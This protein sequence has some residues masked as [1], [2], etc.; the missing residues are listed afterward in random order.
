MTL[1]VKMVVHVMIVSIIKL[2]ARRTLYVNWHFLISHIFKTENEKFL[3]NHIRGHLN[4]TVCLHIMVP[5]VG[6]HHVSPSWVVPL[7]SIMAHVL[8]IITLQLV[9]LV[10]VLLDIAVSPVNGLPVLQIHV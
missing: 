4:A 6:Y 2:F 7:V 3:K 9:M 10:L 8:S 1:H 5:V